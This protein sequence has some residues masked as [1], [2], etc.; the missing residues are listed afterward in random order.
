MIK[1]CVKKRKESEKEEQMEIEFNSEW[2]DT[3][4]SQKSLT[5]NYSV[6]LL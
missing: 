2:K 4:T 6:Y 1:N 3:A 5:L